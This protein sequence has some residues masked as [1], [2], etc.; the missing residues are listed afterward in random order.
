MPPIPFPP[1]GLYLITP[2]AIDIDALAT[3]LPRILPFAACLQYRRKR[4]P[5]SQ[6][7][8]EAQGL[9]AICRAAGTCFIVN[10]DARL[11]RE[12]GADGVHLGEDDGDIAA[13]RTLLGPGRVIGI[14]C[15]DNAARARAAVASGA[16]YVA[17]GAMFPSSTKPSARRATPA[18]F[19]ET[20]SLGVPRVAI[21]GITP[22]NAPVAVAAGADIVAVIG[23]VF[24][25]PDPVAAARAIASAF[26]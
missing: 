15:Y 16:G 11:A 18:L 17:F 26:D 22:D 2:D 3:L 10:D 1:R 24:D 9:R 21:G 4:T 19:A 5:P 6:R 13:A 23:G 14:S 25:A 20:A 12:A 8:S 7:V